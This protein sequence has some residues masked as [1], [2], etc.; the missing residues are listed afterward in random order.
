MAKAIHDSEAQAIGQQVIVACAVV[1]HAFDGIEKIFLPKRADTKKFMPGVY[2]FPGG[3]VDF[4]E[5]IIAG[6]T[7]E[8][9]EECGK[10]IVVGDPFAVFTY[11][12]KVKASHSI[13]VVYFAQFAN[14]VDDITVHLEDHSGYD[15]IAEDELH[16]VLVGGKTVDDEEYIILKKAFALLKGA[17][18]KF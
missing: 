6:L 7:R 15:W 2:E 1:H 18:L 13:E 12:N 16:K 5:D 14:G 4:G 11:E 8:L 3:H 17:R 10:S 9:T